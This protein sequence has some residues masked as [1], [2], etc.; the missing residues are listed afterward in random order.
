MDLCFDIHLDVEIKIQS[1]PRV[2]VV[3]ASSLLTSCV[4]D[5]AVSIFDHL[6]TSLACLLSEIVGLVGPLEL[7]CR[8]G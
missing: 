2:V 7:L 3:A 1:Q 8:F 4:R 6:L 5:L